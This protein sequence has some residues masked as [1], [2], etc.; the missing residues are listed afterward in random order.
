MATVPAFRGQ[1]VATMMMQYGIE[2]ADELNLECF[3]EAS[4]PGH[5]LYEKYEFR[6]LMDFFVNTHKKNASQTWIRLQN[7]YPA[8]NCTLMWRPAPKDISEGKEISFWDVMAR[9]KQAK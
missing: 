3:L 8:I 9:S 1:G 7:E 6:R 2:K 5:D 4:N